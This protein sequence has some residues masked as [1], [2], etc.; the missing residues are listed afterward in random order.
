MEIINNQAK[1]ELQESLLNYALDHNISFI[2]VKAS[3]HDPPLS[4]KEKRSICINTSWYKPEEVP[5]TIGHEIGHI[6]IGDQGFNYFDSFAGKC[7]EEKPADLYALKLIYDYSKSRGDYFSDP[8]I[9]MQS[10]GIPWRMAYA[11]KTLFEYE[12]FFNFLKLKKISYY[13]VSSAKSFFISILYSKFL[14]I[15]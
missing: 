8:G 10:Y 9:F 11:T 13:F 2:L 3:P 6:M 5:F 7:L 1:N 15:I 14:I 12:I 4:F